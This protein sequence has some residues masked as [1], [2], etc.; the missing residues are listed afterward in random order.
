MT[1]FNKARILVGC[2]METSA[3]LLQVKASNEDGY[4][5]LIV[6]SVRLFETENERIKRSGPL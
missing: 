5:R 3:Y 2:A 4:N 1:L 6:D